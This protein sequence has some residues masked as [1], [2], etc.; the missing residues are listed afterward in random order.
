MFNEFIRTRTLGCILFVLIEKYGSLVQSTLP[1]KVSVS[2]FCDTKERP[3]LEIGWVQGN[4]WRICH[5][6]NLICSCLHEY[7]YLV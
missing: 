7:N 5:P 2:V 1:V 3:I 4:L 6:S